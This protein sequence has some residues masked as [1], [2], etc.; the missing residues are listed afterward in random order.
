MPPLSQRDWQSAEGNEAGQPEDQYQENADRADRLRTSHL[1]N[2][3]R[4]EAMNAAL[5]MVAPETES[6]FAFCAVTTS[7]AKMGS[8]LRLMAI[9]V[10]VW[11]GAST[12][13]KLVMAPPLM[14]TFTCT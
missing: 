9:E 2:A 3:D 5:V 1:G 13:Q 12:S 4:T 10:P 8:A 11:E 6:T 14:T 7:C